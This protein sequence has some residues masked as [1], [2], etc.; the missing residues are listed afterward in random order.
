MENTEINNPELENEQDIEAAEGENQDDGEEST[1]QQ[2]NQKESESYL[3]RQKQ[4]FKRDAAMYKQRWLEAQQ[5]INSLQQGRGA[6]NRN[7]GDDSPATD[8]DVKAYVK[9]IYAESRQE[10]E[11]RFRQESMRKDFDNFEAKM[12]AMADKIH[13][14]DDKVS[15][16]KNINT[17]MTGAQL[18]PVGGAE[19]LYHLA[20][21]PQELDRIMRMNPTAQ[22]REVISLAARV[23]Q[24]NKQNSSAPEPSKTPQKMGVSGKGTGTL[25]QQCKDA[26]KKRYGR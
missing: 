3:V 4:R 19:V 17:I 20:N 15:H 11:A 2:G 5:E 22:V 1:E 9:S 26:I 6:N 12:D 23:G 7:Q 24:V 8:E 13:D 16:L 21:K 10:E 14:Y 18:A 25:L